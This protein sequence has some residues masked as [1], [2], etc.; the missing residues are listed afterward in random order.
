MNR[1]GTLLRHPI[2]AGLILLVVVLSIR[3]VKEAWSAWDRGTVALVE[4]GDRKEAIFQFRTASRWSLPGFSLPRE[5]TEKILEL[6][7]EDLSTCEQCVEGWIEGE[8]KEAIPACPSCSL[9]V[10]GFDSGRAGILGSR[11]FYTSNEDLLEPLNGGL[12]RA[13]VLAA[14]VD[15]LGPR[16]VP[17]TREIR[18]ARHWEQ[19]RADHSPPTLPALGSVLG[20]LLWLGGAASSIR[21]WGTRNSPDDKG[22]KIAALV[23]GAGLILWFIFLSNLG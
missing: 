18:T 7:S 14:E 11:S 17:D 19:M 12:V 16:A 22:W 8:D 10:Y 9:A 6:A 20:F 15:P 3:S 2:V 5:A 21:L 23:S 13:L 1:L 4:Y